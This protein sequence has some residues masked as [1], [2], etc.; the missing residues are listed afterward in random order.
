M[1]IPKMKRLT[2]AGL[3]ATLAIRCLS[4][5]QPETPV[6]PEWPPPVLPTDVSTENL[7]RSVDQGVLLAQNAAS[8]ADRV[9]QIADRTDEMLQEYRL[10]I[11]ELEAVNTY[12]DQMMEIIRSQETEI[13]TIEEDL[14]QLQETRRQILPL[15]LKMIDTL[16]EFISRDTPFLLE[17]R[18]EKVATLRALMDRGDISLA[19]KFRNVFEAW[20]IE[21]DLSRN[22][23]AYKAPIPLNGEEIT[24]EFLRFGRVGLYFQSLDGQTTGWWNPNTRQF[25]VL[26][27]DAYRVSVGQALK[28]A[29][30]QAPKNLLNLPIP[31]PTQVSS[32]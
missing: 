27:G 2:L 23:E 29:N 20:Q 11:R 28:I 10:V 9:A 26:E 19:E 30:N 1:I 7:E 5:Q 17:E 16:D 13:A 24:V 8:T 21:N 3:L 32:N 14:A 22:I 18:R 6:T 31:A 4:G 15:L 12:N 25:E